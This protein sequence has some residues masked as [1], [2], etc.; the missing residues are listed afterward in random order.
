MSEFA[1]RLTS[2]YLVPFL[3][4][5]RAFPRRN[6]HVLNSLLSTDS[7]LI[8]SQ[9]LGLITDVK[10]YIK[11]ERKCKR[12]ESIKLAYLSL[13]LLPNVRPVWPCGPS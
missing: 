11:S 10:K 9:S 8:P 2:N 12:E 7:Y 3:V 4:H 1:D 13:D 6:L 5:L